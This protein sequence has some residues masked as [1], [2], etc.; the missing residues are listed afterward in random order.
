MNAIRLPLK[1]GEA[2]WFDLTTGKV[3]VAPITLSPGAA[4]K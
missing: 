2:I 1:P 4:P 3:Y